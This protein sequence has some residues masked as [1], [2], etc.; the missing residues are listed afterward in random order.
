[1]AKSLLG[2]L[3]KALLMAGS[4]AV[5]MSS[6]GLPRGGHRATIKQRRRSLEHCGA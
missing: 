5:P 1:M 3:N 4:A 6:G 2:C